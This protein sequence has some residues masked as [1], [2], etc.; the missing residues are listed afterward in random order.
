[1]IGRIYKTYTSDCPSRTSECESL[2]SSAF[3][4]GLPAY[5]STKGDSET[6]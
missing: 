4:K 3:A 6:R 5:G 1:M 2:D